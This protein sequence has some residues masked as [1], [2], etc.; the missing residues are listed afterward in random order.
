VLEVGHNFAVAFELMLLPT[1][2]LQA[3]REGDRVACDE[4]FDWLYDLLL[5]Y[6]K[7]YFKQALSEDVLQETAMGVYKKLAKAPDDP[8]LFRDWVYGFA[9]N[10]V[11]QTVRKAWFRRVRVLLPD[12]PELAPP[13]PGP[14]TSLR[15]KERL[16]AV[17]L[18][19][20]PKLPDIYQEAVLHVARG[21]SYRTLAVAAQI[22]EGSAR[23]RIHEAR[24]QLRRLVRDARR[25]RPELQSPN[26]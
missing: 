26:V 4:L 2:V 8:T 1:D 10:E 7:K 15:D 19:C 22:P 18:E 16:N 6:F 11:R 25:T 9:W 17:A 12:S 23:Q 21:G 24:K 3:A 13:Q 5:P 14:E 20:L